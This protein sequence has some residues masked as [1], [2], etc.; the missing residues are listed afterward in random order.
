M[1]AWPGAQ[2]AWYYHLPAVCGD[3]EVGDLIDTSLLPL[4]QAHRETGRKILLALT[5]ALV[6]RLAALRPSAI[7]SVGGLVEDGL[8]E[9][10]GTTYH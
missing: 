10:G 3:D 9:L 7:E 6:D 2:I 5:G 8:C 1:T 4:V